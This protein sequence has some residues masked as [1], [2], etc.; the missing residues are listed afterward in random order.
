MKDISELRS[1]INEINEQ[2]LDLFLERMGLAEEVAAY[3][4]ANNK[5]ILDPARER[6]ILAWAEKHS[7]ELGVYSYS[8][9]ATLM[10]LS[11]ARQGELLSGGTAIRERI[12]KALAAGGEV[13]P[14]TGTVACQGVEGA[15]SQAA[16][17]KLLPRGEI[18]YV[19][20]FEA[21][22]DA[23]ES[24]L[25]KFGVLPLENSTAGSVRSVY[26]LL[27]KKQFSIV[28]GTQL[29]IRHELL[30]K[31]GIKL[32]EV[33]EIYSHEQ[34]IAQCGRFLTS[35]GNTVKIIPCS[36]TAAAARMVAE[37][38]RRDCAA[39]SSPQCASL[40][41]LEVL[42]EDIQ[43][44]ANNYTRF[45]C[46]TKDPVIYEGADHISLM[47]S[48]DNKPGALYS[49]LSKL[50]VR[51]INMSKL[52]SS[53]VEGRDFLFDFF[54]DLDASVKEPGVMAMLEDLDRSYEGVH[55]LGCYSMV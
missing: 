14:R 6:E 20:T 32:S 5:P 18:V 19:K 15:N 50:S 40:Y 13:F 53:P 46:I 8:L 12:E 37:S 2:I 42:G 7:G 54:V 43:D 21:V 39:I 34:A 49:I 55:F 4:K 31:P 41:G 48:C 25:C 45:I 26:Q 22:F 38:D 47:I 9:F 52:E 33:K 17:D 24:G 36:N 11:R 44:N 1:R 10:E 23:V 30:V 29:C 3:K 27:K 51:G 28:R 35:L 16:C